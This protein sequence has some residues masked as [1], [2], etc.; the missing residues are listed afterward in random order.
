MGGAAA[1]TLKLAHTS[2]VLFDPDVNLAMTFLSILAFLN[3]ALGIVYVRGLLRWRLFRFIFGGADAHTSDEEVF[4]ELLYESRLVHTIM[5]TDALSP[6]KRLVTAVTLNE[7]DIQRLVL[8][9]TQEKDDV[10]APLWAAIGPDERKALKGRFKTT[11]AK[12]A[13]GE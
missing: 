5:S 3:Q 12:W 9:E 2:A 6:W 4:V 1:F 8:E 13:K 7:D 10:I 11:A